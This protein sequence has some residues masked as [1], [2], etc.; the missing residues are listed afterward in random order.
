METTQLKEKI[1]ANAP[2]G[3][4]FTL[5]EEN[6]T[7]LR[8]ECS[9]EALYSLCWACTRAGGVF[10]SAFISNSGK[11]AFE[12]SYVFRVQDADR[13]VAMCA[14]GKEFFSISHLIPAAIWDER[15]MQDVTGLKFGRMADSRALIFHPEAG[16]P[17]KRPLSQSAI[18]ESEIDKSYPMPGTGAHGEY[19]IPVGPVHAGIIEPGHFRFHVV[20]EPILKMETRMFFLHRGIEAFAEG[21]TFSEAVPLMEQ[22]SGD[23]TAANSVAFAQAVESACGM[24][25]P[26]R[27]KYLRTV[28][29]EM[30]RIY[31]HLADLGGM[32]TDVG[33]YGASSRFTLLREEM[34]RLNKEVSGNRFLR[35]LIAIGGMSRDI[36]DDALSTLSNK[37]KRFLAM[38][39]ELQE[40]TLSSS[41]FLDRAFSTG[42]VSA[43]IARE[44]ALVGPGARASGI[45]CDARVHYP[46]A[47]YGKIKVQE[48][49]ETNGDV[50]SRFFVK[51]TEVRNAAAI[52]LEAMDKMPKGAVLSKDSATA[53]DGKIG[54]GWAEAPRGSCMFMVEAAK[55]GKIRR[56]ACRTASFRNWR[57]LEQAVLG[58]IVPDF[59]LINKSFNLSYAGCDL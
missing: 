34:M 43:D 23:E 52:M 12:V 14:S 53:S 51:L 9:P 49:L 46:Y 4:K 39:D 28:L 10:D 54:F 18:K 15:K 13:M 37:L 7:M 29:L 50:L 33:F 55:G 25:V 58:N 45:S 57:A 44:L 35:G 5:R 42:I 8:L 24:D 40:I 20:G 17:D 48:A 19:E 47:A 59:P 6:E 26:E 36:P 2:S 21:K 31:S 30:E 38:L 3:M 1:A 56:L 16:M 11:G 27:A 32:A 41:T 22:I